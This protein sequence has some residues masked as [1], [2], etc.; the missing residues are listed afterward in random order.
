VNDGFLKDFLDGRKYKTDIV[1]AFLMAFLGLAFAV[2][3]PDGNILRIVFGIAMLTFVPGYSLVSALWPKAMLA[4]GT[5]NSQQNPDAASIDNLERIALSF[6]L[7]IALLSITGLIL[8]FAGPGITLESTLASNIILIVIFLSLALFRR[9]RIPYEEVY[10]IGIDFDGR[11]P[12]DRTERLITVAIGISLVLA[13]ITLAYSITIPG[14]ESHYSSLYILDSNATAQD[15]PDVMNISS[16]GT[17]IVGIS[18]NEHATTQY[19]LLVGI[20]GS[21]ERNYT[22]NWA[23]PITFDSD[24]LLTRNITLGHGE[25]FE[26]PFTFTISLPGTYKI[27]W[28]IE[29]DG[30]PTDYSTHLWVTVNVD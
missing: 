24:M 2:A 22:D 18:C 15:Y 14:V 9:S 30:I 6:G 26:E 17:V 21:H 10:R 8:H 11:M 28:Q 7:S 25:S 16:N 19:T 4:G 12:Q 1:L 23:N 29:I 13:G 3:L 27:N 5:E 20:E